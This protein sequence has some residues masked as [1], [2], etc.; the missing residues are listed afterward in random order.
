MNAKRLTRRRFVI[1]AGSTAVLAG[2]RGG[3]RRVRRPAFALGGSASLEPAASEAER[4]CL[5]RESAHATSVE[6]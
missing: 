5:A 1:G 3:E 4:F 2:G 6:A